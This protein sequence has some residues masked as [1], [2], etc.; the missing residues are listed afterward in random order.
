M[1]QLLNYCILPAHVCII[2]LS[3]DRLFSTNFIVRTDCFYQLCYY[4]LCRSCAYAVL[5]FSYLCCVDPMFMLCSPCIYAVY[6]LCISCCSRFTGEFIVGRVIKAMNNSWHPDCFLCE[7]CTAPLAD[8]GFV[9]NA[10]R[11]VTVTPFIV[12]ECSAYYFG[13]GFYFT[14]SF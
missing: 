4:M 11:Y 2:L 8:E 10:G 13:G 7:I 9:K 1:L 6:H 12:E 5:Y 14:F 3:L